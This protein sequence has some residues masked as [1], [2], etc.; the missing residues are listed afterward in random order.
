MGLLDLIRANGVAL[1]EVRR[2]LEI[3]QMIPVFCFCE[4]L[5]FVHAVVRG[6]LAAQ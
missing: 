3:S 1:L 2:Q 6:L 4:Q 5:P